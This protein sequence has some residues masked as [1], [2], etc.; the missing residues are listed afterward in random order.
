M[1]WAKQFIYLAQTEG[2]HFFTTVVKIIIL[3][4]DF[5]QLLLET[6]GNS[7]LGYLLT[8]ESI[9]GP[10]SLILVFPCWKSPLESTIIII[11]IIIFILFYIILSI[12]PG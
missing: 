5:K 12:V 10:N 11:I 9:C 7:F 3:F 4:I 2:R 6:I 1:F 8:T